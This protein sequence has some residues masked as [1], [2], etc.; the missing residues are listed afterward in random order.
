MP[1]S[2]RQPSGP[3]WKKWLMGCGIGCG[4]LVV[5]LLILAAVLYHKAMAV[6]PEARQPAQPAATPGA[7]HP[8]V[9]AAPECPPFEQQRQEIERV[10]SRGQP[11]NV[12]MRLTEGQINDLI[13]QNAGADSGLQNLRASLGIGDITLTGTTYWRGR[14]VY[15]T[16]TGRP[17]AVGGRPRFELYSVRV[18]TLGLPASAVAQFQAE[19][20]RGLDDWAAKNPFDVTDV[21]VYDGELVMS[22]TTRPR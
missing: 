3:A 18:G 22:G 21:S 20:D 15:L 8:G 5:L 12:N 6:P 1:H 9:A 4:S 14:Q 10:A 7:A 13:A 16:A 2:R 17:Q 19:I 11:A